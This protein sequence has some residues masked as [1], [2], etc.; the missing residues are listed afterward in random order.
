LTTC[1]AAGLRISE[2]VTLT[3]AAI[4][5]KRMVLRVEQG[6]GKKD[7]H[8]HPSS[9][10]LTKRGIMSHRQAE[11]QANQG[12]AVCRMGLA[13]EADCRILYLSYVWL[14][15]SYIVRTTRNCAL[16]LIIRA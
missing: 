8:L 5:S 4:D 14:L 2:A 6:K 1:Y 3:P 15:S 16:P 12:Q 13:G 11:R 10:A 7:A 9:F